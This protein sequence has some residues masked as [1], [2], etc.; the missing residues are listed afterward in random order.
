MFD[1]ALN[2]PLTNF[3]NT[4]AKSNYTDFEHYSNNH[5]LVGEKGKTSLNRIHT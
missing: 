5:Q 4:T 3:H 2:S 1:R